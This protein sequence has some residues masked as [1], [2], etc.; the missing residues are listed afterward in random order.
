MTCICC[1]TGVLDLG[2]LTICDSLTISY[3]APST[4]TYTLQLDYNGVVVEIEAVITAG[5]PLVFDLS[6]LNENYTYTAKVLDGNRAVIIFTNGG[7]DSFDCLRFKT[8]IGVGANLATIP[9]S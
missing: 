1:D 9:L 5:N 2:C 4:Q 3:I 7:G 8:A 6:T